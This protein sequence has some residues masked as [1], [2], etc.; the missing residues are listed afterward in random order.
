MA[1]GGPNDFLIFFG[2]ADG[3]ILS[4]RRERKQR[5]LHRE[6]YGTGY[7]GAIYRC[8]FPIAIT[9]PLDKN[10]KSAIIRV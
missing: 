4:D 9:K 7:H 8:T 2:I 10:T 1:G 3:K 5:Y 6:S